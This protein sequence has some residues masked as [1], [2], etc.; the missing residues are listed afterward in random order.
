MLV[1]PGD[2][3]S[4]TPQLR[5]VEDCDMPQFM[6]Q[7]DPQ[8]YR[9]LTSKSM[10]DPSDYLKDMHFL[11]N[12]DDEAGKF[13]DVI[14]MRVMLFALFSDDQLRSLMHDYL[15]SIYFPAT[16]INFYRGLMDMEYHPHAA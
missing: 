15:P 14:L 11:S 13:L 6:R 3:A 12:T 8:L 7:S 9:S 16:Y 10:E 1:I 4:S 5:V 2:G